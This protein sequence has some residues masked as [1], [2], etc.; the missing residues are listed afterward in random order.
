MKSL[1]TIALIGF[2]F[3][4]SAQTT[5]TRQ[6]IGSAGGSFSNASIDVNYTAGEAVI[7]TLSGGS[8]VLTQGFQQ[9][10]VGIGSLD[11][12]VVN[13]DITLYPNPTQG[14]LNVQFSENAVKY[15]TLSVRVY[16]LQGKLVFADDET[17]L[18]G[19]N[20][21]LQ[22]DLSGLNTGHYH[23][24]IKDSEGG[25]SHSRFVVY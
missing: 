3:G 11:E 14:E 23:I 13:N 8:R 2:A 10:V 15:G 9:A 21:V 12:L 18:S 24:H 4:A 17:V 20:G 22:L 25:V 5:I 16:D 19:Q 6:V 7:E 1:V